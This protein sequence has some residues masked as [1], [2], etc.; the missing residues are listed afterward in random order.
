MK[1]NRA[2]H[3]IVSRDRLSPAFLADENRTDR[4]ELVSFDDGEVVLFW[5]L[6]PKFAV[7][8]LREMRADLAGLEA[9][10]FF[11]KWASVQEGF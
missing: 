11:E 5:E 4:V 3:L 6:P 1:A 7:R 8:M 9:T 2:Y 10:E